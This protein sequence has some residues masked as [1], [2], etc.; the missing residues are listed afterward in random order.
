M[1]ASE[2]VISLLICLFNGSNR[3][4][5]SA[6]AVLPYVTYT[7]TGREFS[8]SLSLCVYVCTA[9]YLTTMPRCTFDKVAAFSM[10]VNC[11]NALYILDP[12]IHS[13]VRYNALMLVALCTEVDRTRASVVCL[14]F[15]M[16]RIYPWEFATLI[17]Q[18]LV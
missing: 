18:T 9:L 5:S 2:N 11:T 17:S 10:R 13:A 12:Y 4:D 16:A 8:L 1:N 6:I 15:A 7:S 3:H 14:V